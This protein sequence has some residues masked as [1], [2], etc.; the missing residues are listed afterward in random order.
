MTPGLDFIKPSSATGQLTAADAIP[1]YTYFWSTRPGD[2]ARDAVLMLNDGWG[3]IDDAIKVFGKD[4]KWAE[5]ILKAGNT[6]LPAELRQQIGRAVAESPNPAEAALKVSD[7]LLGLQRVAQA[8]DNVPGGSMTEGV[9]RGIPSQLDRILEYRLP[10]DW[11]RGT[12]YIV[13]VPKNAT[14]LDDNIVRN[15]ASVAG[16]KILGP[17]SR[18]VGEINAPNTFGEVQENAM[19]AMQSLGMEEY[20]RLGTENP[21]AFG[22]SMAPDIQEIIDA[23]RAAKIGRFTNAIPTP[24]LISQ[25]EA[26]LRALATLARLEAQNNR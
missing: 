4:R 25:K 26:Q 13:D 10:E 6:T 19:R 5:G 15:S 23:V 7:F 8:I 21:M 18:V 9:A 20:L 12:S 1:G 17:V 14:T 22:N 3:K 11:W 24:A 2:N 16:R